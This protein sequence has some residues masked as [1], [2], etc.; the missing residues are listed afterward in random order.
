MLQLRQLER[1]E[2]AE[3]TSTRDKDWSIRQGLVFV[4]G[5]LMAALSLAAIAYLVPTRLSLDTT[6]PEL[7][8]FKLAQDL[9][10]LSPAD[11]WALWRFI[12]NSGLKARQAPNYLRNRGR[13]AWLKVWIN[14]AAGG[15]ETGIVVAAIS[16]RIKPGA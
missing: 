8:D 1:A 2:P 3:A 12:E 7:A 9:D 4:A 11:T 13:A 6:K 10:S 15:A 14:I 5:I 16:F